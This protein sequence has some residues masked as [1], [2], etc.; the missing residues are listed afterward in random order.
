MSAN[1]AWHSGWPNTSRLTEPPT[2][3]RRLYD[4]R[5]PD[6]FSLDVHVARRFQLQRS[7][8]EIYLD[9]TNATQRKNIG[10]YRYE[11]SEDPT[12]SND[13]IMAN[14]RKLLPAIP[15]LG[16]TWNW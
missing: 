9:L 3:T 4:Q 13:G 14:D 15:A 1:A 8:L 7:E 11:R 5:L 12:V 2:S 16:V 10:G 6:Y